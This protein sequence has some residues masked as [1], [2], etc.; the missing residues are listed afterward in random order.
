MP[1]GLLRLSNA[2]V[3]LISLRRSY[4]NIELIEIFSFASRLH[5]EHLSERFYSLSFNLG[6]RVLI[7][8]H[9]LVFFDQVEEGIIL[10]DD[11]PDFFLYCTFCSV[12]AM[13][14]V[15]G[16]NFQDGQ[17]RGDGS[18]NHCWGWAS[19]LF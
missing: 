10:E 9:L 17:W 4:L 16:N 8:H 18:C 13:I 12:I 6:S 5:R 11:H 2:L 15:S 7:C 14:L 3:I 19:F 1:S